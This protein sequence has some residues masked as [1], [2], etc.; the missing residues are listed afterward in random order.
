PH[1]ERRATAC[2]TPPA[3]PPCRRAPPASRSPCAQ[4]EASWRQVQ[5]ALERALDLPDRVESLAD[6]AT[7]HGVELADVQLVVGGLP[8]LQ[9]LDLVLDPQS[10]EELIRLPQLA[11]VAGPKRA[12]RG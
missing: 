1:S 8:R 4:R 9:L 11:G 7:D 2:R 6:I 12:R 5:L 3:A 10:P